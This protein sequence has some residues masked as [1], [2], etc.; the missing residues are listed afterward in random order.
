MNISQFA[1]RILFSTSLEDKLLAPEVLTYDLSARQ[2]RNLDQLSS[3]H[4]PVGMEMQA[5]GAKAIAPPR[6]DQLDNEISRGRLL[7]Y[8]AN[9]ELLATELMALVL[10]K[11]PDAPPSFR[12]GVLVT[13]QEEQEHTRMYLKR[14][15]E[16]GVEFGSYPLSGQFWNVVA[17]M[18]SP[19]DFVSRLSLTFEQANLDYSQH[20]AKVFRRLGDVPT[21][22]LLEKIYEDEIGHVKH[23][24]HWFRQWKDPNLDD[25]EAYRK[26][27]EFPMSPQ[28]GKGP[29][30]QFNREG[31]QLAGLS[32]SFIDAIEVFQQSRG[33]RATLRW[34][35]AGVEQELA[36][37]NRSDSLLEQLSTD[38]ELVMISL[39]KPDDILLLRKLPSQSLRKKL[40]SAG[41]K[42]PEFAS[43]EETHRLV[44]R[45]LF[46]F[47]PWAWSPDNMQRVEPLAN[48]VRHRPLPWCEIRQRLFRKSWSVEV[49]QSALKK[50]PIEYHWLPDPSCAGQI[51]RDVD[52]LAKR[53][54]DC[55][56]ETLLF[57]QDLATTGR[58]QRRF[59]AGQDLTPIDLDWLNCRIPSNKY[60]PMGVLEPLLNRILDLSFLYRWNREIETP[61]F[62]GFT[63]PLMHGRRYIGTR[64]TNPIQNESAEVKRFLLSDRG[65]VLTQVQS[66]IESY[67]IPNLPKGRVEGH[68]G[69]DVMVF[70]NQSGQ[71]KIKPLVELNPRTTMGHIALGF[72][73][74]IA[75]GS[76]ATFEI[77]SIADWKPE[78]TDCLAPITLSQSGHIQAGCIPLV[79]VDPSTKLVP[80]LKVYSNSRELARRQ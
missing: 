53:L 36:G 47:E 5:E 75:P 10:L 78:T 8:L 49:L 21:A 13:L 68:F 45:K 14:M 38:L 37:T 25:W 69:V 54:R 4:R 80:V 50:S 27:L 33:R 2:I 57:K 79:D 52:D 41:F 66:W 28:R 63:R 17:P 72:S 46:E 23:G 62:L 20:F 61:K 77:I 1:E 76:E 3:P 9:H 30:I 22:S 29:G 58:G 42:L 19:M 18:R 26:T 64:L 44:D 32:N 59:L 67:L 43:I 55:P 51:V 65:K 34:F 16:C 48:H 56:G 39:S 74:R 70:R 73:K 11:F 71:L 24:L 31:R 60:E 7:H 35:D 12:Q 40:L 6:D 15:R